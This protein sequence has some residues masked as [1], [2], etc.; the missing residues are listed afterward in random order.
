VD[1]ESNRDFAAQKEKAAAKRELKKLEEMGEADK[2]SLQ[3]T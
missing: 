2:S 1:L 3:G